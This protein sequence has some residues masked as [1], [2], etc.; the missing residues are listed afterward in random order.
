MS[1][2]AKATEFGRMVFSDYIV[3]TKNGQIINF[4]C[5][6]GDEECD[7]EWRWVDT[8]FQA[9]VTE[10]GLSIESIQKLFYARNMSI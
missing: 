4:Y 1:N 9:I 5:D 7:V 10:Y 2:E 8:I 3:I 6:S